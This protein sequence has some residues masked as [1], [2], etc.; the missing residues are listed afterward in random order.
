MKI[1]KVKIRCFVVTVHVL[2]AAKILRLS[3]FKHEGA[4]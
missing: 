1:K 2:N 3:L 4:L